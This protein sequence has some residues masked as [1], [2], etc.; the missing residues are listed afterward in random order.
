[1]KAGYGN[2]ATHKKGSNIK[3]NTRNPKEF[4]GHGGS[5]SHKNSSVTEGRPGPSAGK[6]GGHV[7]STSY[8]GAGLKR[9]PL[10][11]PTGTSHHPDVA[12]ALK[13]IRKANK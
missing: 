1:M 3:A 9:V 5:Y 8:K 2:G 11:D 12:T 4:S 13:K 7:R 6:K 10:F